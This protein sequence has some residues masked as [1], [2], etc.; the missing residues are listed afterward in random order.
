MIRDYSTGCC[1]MESKKLRFLI[2]LLV[3]VGTL[4]VG[5]LAGYFIV[6]AIHP[7]GHG[8]GTNTTGPVVPVQNITDFVL[9]YLFWVMSTQNY[10]PEK[11]YTG[12]TLED[13]WF[14]KMHLICA[15]DPANKVSQYYIKIHD[16]NGTFH[17]V[18]N[19]GLLDRS[20]VANATGLWTF[21]SIQSEKYNP[22]TYCEVPTN[23]VPVDV[24][25]V[26]TKRYID[27]MW[28]YGI[29]VR[30]YDHNTN[31]SWWWADPSHI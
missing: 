17:L 19:N 9:K 27:P 23:N 5:V 16:A 1:R 11:G 25:N 7:I 24:Q 8:N 29:G 22:F 20:D 3:G 6:K 28:G 15:T 12:L 26:F 2:V 21:Y 13:Q 10:S 30:L 18:D 31:L 4:T 14:M